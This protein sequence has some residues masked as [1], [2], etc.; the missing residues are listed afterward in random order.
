MRDIGHFIG[1]R[2]VAGT[3]GKFGDVFNPATG[4]VT[5]ASRWPMRPRS[6]RPSPPP[7]PPCRPG[8]RR[9]RC[10][11]RASCSSSRSCS[12]A[13]AGTR[14]PHHRR[15]RQGAVRRRR[16][17]A[18]RPR[19][20]R[21]RLRHPAAAEG[22]VH[23]ARRHR[24]RQLVGAPAAR[25][26][27][28]HHAVQLPADGADVDVPG[29]DRL[30]QHLRAE[31]VGDA[32][33]RPSLRSPSCSPR[34]ACRTACSTSCT[35]TRE[36]VDAL[37][38][39]P[40]VAAVSFVGSTPIAEYIY[41]AARARQARAGAG[42]RQEPHGGDAGRRS[43]SSGRCADGRGLR[44]GRRALHGDLGRGRGRRSPATRWSQKLA[45]RVRALKIGAGHRSGRRDGSAGHARAPR[46]GRGYIDLGVKEGAKLVV[47]GRG[48]SRAGLRER[49]LPRRL[50]VRRRRHRDAHLPGGDLR[51]GARVVRAPDFAGA[52]RPGE[53]A[54]VRQRRRDL[55]PRR[56]RGARLR[57][58][59]SRSAWSASTCRSRC[60]WRSTS[61]GGWKRS[62]FG[63]HH[64]YGP[65]GVRFYTRYK[66]V[67]QRWPTGARRGAEYVMPTLG[68]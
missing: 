33:R 19:G 34:P 25:R 41:A 4:E 32:T 48:L 44:L 23:R 55:H 21:V 45:P 20:R 11:A 68:G 31:A 9:R 49:L 14:R 26:V 28:R 36:A 59:A 38:T 53:R 57:A 12:S 56:R 67:T 43:R 51:P 62:L 42:R 50:A 52:V 47:D 16:R 35:A 1:G 18:A 37:L 30:R 5:A 24:H 13:T 27:R 29:G 58:P 66:T 46:Q 39:H 63:D 65:E 15:A 40:D 54:R 3:S 2:P 17:G 64:M 10:G 60:R 22:R 7:R 8:P 61:F 6:T